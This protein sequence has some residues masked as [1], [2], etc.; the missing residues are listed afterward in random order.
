LNFKLLK[1]QTTNLD[2]QSFTFLSFPTVNQYTHSLMAKRR[3]GRP[4]HIPELEDHA[5]SPPIDAESDPTLAADPTAKPRPKP[6]PKPV[7]KTI[8][9]AQSML[10]AVDDP[11]VPQQHPKRGRSRSG[12]DDI[13]ASIVQPLAKKTKLSNN[14]LPVQRG[15]NVG[16]SGPKVLPPRSP[17]PSRASRAVKPG[18]P[19]LPRKKRTSAEVAAAA[20]QK[21]N[22]RLELEKIE[23]DKIRMLAEMEA[24]EEEEERDEERMRIQDISDLAESHVISESGKEGMAGDEGMAEDEGMAGDDD[25]VMADEEVEEFV[26]VDS[27]PELEGPET[28]KKVS[29]SR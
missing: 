15:G 25:I 23:K 11:E 13:P 17:L 29:D 20:Q 9:S 24:V 10:D 4:K 7:K 28:V 5:T 1:F 8:A 22:L 26:E 6:R 2:I 19:D 18:A 3:V 14:T 12:T 27:E 16:K 21:K